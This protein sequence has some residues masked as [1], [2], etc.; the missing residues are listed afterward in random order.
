MNKWLEEKRSHSNEDAISEINCYIAG[1]DKSYKFEKN[2]ETGA[3]LDGENLDIFLFAQIYQTTLLCR[4]HNAIIWVT[5]N[6]FFWRVV[7][8]LFEIKRSEYEEFHDQYR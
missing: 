6:N 4:V 3:S 7:F 8:C 1:L 2:Q 5:E